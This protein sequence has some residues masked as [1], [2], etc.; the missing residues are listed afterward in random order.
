M[1]RRRP[2][3]VLARG[4]YGI[5]C[6]I[7]WSYRIVTRFSEVEH[8]L[9]EWVFQPGATWLRSPALGSIKCRIVR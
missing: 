8:E 5:L 3:T 7:P 2:E 1:P 4:A 6:E 9:V